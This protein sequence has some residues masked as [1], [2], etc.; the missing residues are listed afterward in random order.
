MLLLLPQLIF[1]SFYKFKKS[2]YDIQYWIDRSK[3]FQSLETL[4]STKNVEFLG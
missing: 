3:L 2:E 1:S 4:F